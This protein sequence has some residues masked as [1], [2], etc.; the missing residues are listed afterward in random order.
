[1]VQDLGLRLLMRQDRAAERARSDEDIKLSL[2]ASGRE[3]REIYPEFFPKEA[4][5][6][7]VFDDDTPDDV[8]TNP[9]A[10]Y[11]YS[12]VEWKSPKD[13]TPEEREAWDSFMG[14]T[15]VSVSSSDIEKNEDGW[16]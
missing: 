8:L 9:D 4:V 10:M 14:D 11:D 15:S 7:T 2:L 12:A 6:E 1:M 13:M 5:K 3:F 16:I